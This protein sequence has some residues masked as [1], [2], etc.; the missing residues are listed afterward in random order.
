MAPKKRKAAQSDGDS[1]PLLKKGRGRPPNPNPTTLASSS[2][3]KGKSVPPQQTA[4]SSRPKRK[5]A[6]IKEATST[7]S[8]K[9]KTDG[10]TKPVAKATKAVKTSTVASPVKPKKPAKTASKRKTSQKETRESSISVEIPHVYTTTA[11]AVNEEVEGEEDSQGPSY[12]LMK[13][14][15]ESRIEKGKDVKFSIDDLKTAAD[16]EAWDGESL[17]SWEILMQ[18]GTA[19]QVQGF[20]ILQVRYCYMMISYGA[21]VLAARNNMRAMMKGDLAF[22]YHSNCKV[23]GIAGIMEIVEE[24]SVDGELFQWTRSIST[25]AATY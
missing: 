20:G 17:V 15:P 11:D 14:E 12:W 6:A 18:R 4:T 22:F 16:P 13:A 24:H 9:S 25:N 7:V 5:S 2:P 21:D 19:N 3:P 23:P 10:V 8:R 1:A